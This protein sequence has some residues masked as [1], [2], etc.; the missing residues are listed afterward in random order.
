MLYGYFYLFL[1]IGGVTNI[2]NNFNI[3]NFITNDFLNLLI[4]LLI[5]TVLACILV[6]FSY[7]L[8]YQK[9]DSDKLSIYECGY[10]PYENTRHNFNIRFYLVAI[11]FIIFDIEVLYMI[12]WCLSIS[13]ANLLNFWSMID[14]IFEL[15]LGF[16]Y[17]WYTNSLNWE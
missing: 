1:F 2:M 15:N 10:E 9:P 16:F 13:K 14:F 4:L 3:S 11:F 12:P 6:L 8:M 17:I 7:F 5:S